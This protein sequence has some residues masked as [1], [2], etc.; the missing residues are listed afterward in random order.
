MANQRSQ[1]NKEKVEK[2]QKDIV[3]L[4]HGSGI[5]RVEITPIG[6][7]RFTSLNPCKRRIRDGERPRQG[8]EINFEENATNGEYVISTLENLISMVGESQVVEFYFEV[9]DS[10]ERIVYAYTFSVLNQDR[11]EAKREAWRA[12]KEAKEYFGT[13]ERYSI[14]LEAIAA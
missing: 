10:S 9:R 3:N 12:L 13:N 5:N 7:R 14:K 2:L 11:E 6:G 8:V 4:I 1:V